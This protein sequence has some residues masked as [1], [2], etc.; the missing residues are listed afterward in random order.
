MSRVIVRRASY[1][2][3]SLRNHVFEMLEAFVGGEIGGN[4]RVVIKPNLLA[5]AAPDRAMLTHP[6]IVRAVAE[7][8]LD[9]GAH[10]QISD[11]Q[12][13]G[14]FRKLLQVSGIAGAC[15][16]L[17]VTFKEFEESVEVDVGEPFHRIHLARDAMEADLLI[18]LPKLK[19]H[20]QML[21]T[22]GVKNL[23]GCVVGFRKPQWHMRTGIDRELFASLLVKIYRTLSPAVT[24][25]D[26]ILAM[27]GPGPG[28]GG[29]PREIGV[30]VAGDDAFAIDAA[31]CEMI[32]LEP[33]RLLTLKMAMKTGFSGGTAET[34]GSLPR[35][36]NFRLPRITPVIFGPPWVHG[37]LRRYLVQR[38]VV[39]AS[40]CRLCGDCCKYCPAGAITRERKAVVFDYDKCIRCYCCLE[41]CPH[42]ALKAEE[43][44]LGR[45]VA[46]S[47]DKMK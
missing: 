29:I 24:I 36:E 37:F 13:M 33:E 20:S 26:G 15:E 47:M 7:Y 9:R 18:N 14:S 2:Y 45:V 25:L 42:G 44:T 35:I 34:E 32:G 3:R 19:T 17:D 10:P 16:G 43:P 23:F 12:A 21:M 39:D 11:S 40:L 46:W 38:P 28:K 1:E 27:E 6:L 22:L 30:L 5:P 31:V 8:V 4:S 41:V